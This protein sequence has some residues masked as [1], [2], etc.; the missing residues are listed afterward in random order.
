MKEMK[1]ISECFD[2]FKGQPLRIAIT[3]HHK[4]DGDAIGSLLAAKFF[5]EKLGHQCVGIV[6]SEVPE[7]LDWMPHISSLL[8][9]EAEAVKVE[10]AI[11]NIDV[12]LCLD[13]NDFGRVKYMKATLEQLDCTKV[14]IDHHMFPSTVF[15]YGISLPEKSSTCEMVYDFINAMGCNELIDE[16]IARCIYTG[17]LT[18]TGSFRFPIVTAHVH[19]MIADLMD[20]GLKHSPIHE[21]IFDNNSLGRMQ[22]M[23]TVLKEKM[24]IFP[25]MKSG[26]I[27]IS[28]EDLALYNAQA[29]DTEGLV[30]LPLSIKDIVFSTLI[31][32]RTDGV[33]M[34]FR[35]K[36]NVDVNAFARTYF[37]G[38]GHFNASGGQSS[39]D[40]TETIVRFKQI[41]SEIHTQIIN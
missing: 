33:K 19:R 3:T 31:I 8:N 23:G 5:L 6:P 22:L 17:T 34:S 32:E 36:G 21:A 4:P 15:D 16:Q 11:K 12:L 26:L 27:A 25:K 38:G 20:K 14:L 40:F 9:Y 18:D 35:S 10:T 1:P 37:N 2:L 30:N 28:L 13:F 7:F 41:L 24:E 39:Q 29:G